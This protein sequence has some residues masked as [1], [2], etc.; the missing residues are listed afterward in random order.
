ML[1]SWM[2]L[3]HDGLQPV[4][5]F[6]W[7]RLV[8]TIYKLASIVKAVYFLVTC[9]HALVSDGGGGSF[10]FHRYGLTIIGPGAKM[11]GCVAAFVPSTPRQPR[12]PMI[13]IA[14]AP[15]AV[16]RSGWLVN[17]SAAVDYPQKQRAIRQRQL[18]VWLSMYV[19]GHI[20]RWCWRRQAAAAAEL[21]S[22][23]SVADVPHNVTAASY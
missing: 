23:A 6:G 12:P 5:E 2:S 17:P 19:N 14:P 22:A 13:P 1:S 15:R 8:S 4:S 9:G 16:K 20:D 11:P 21:I 7:F 10:H 18:H 3:D